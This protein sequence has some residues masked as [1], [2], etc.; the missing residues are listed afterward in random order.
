MIRI[1]AI[2]IAERRSPTRREAAVQEQRAGSETG[3]P[4][5]LPSHSLPTISLPWLRLFSWYSGRYVRRHFHSL[6]VSRAIPFAPPAGVPLVIYSNHASWWDPLV[7][8]LL[9]AEFLPGK[10]VFAPMDAMALKRYGFFKRLGMFGVEQGSRR[11]GVQFLRTARTI[12]QQPN[13]VLWLTPQSRFADARERPV[14]FKPGI[15]H[16]PG[17]TPEIHF[18]PVAI[19][20][21]FWEERLPEVL[22]RFGEPYRATREDVSVKSEWWTEFFADRLR[23]TQGEL[24]KQAQHRDP[25]EFRCLLRGRAGVGGIYDRWRQFKAGWRGKSFQLEHGKL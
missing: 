3:A 22:V 8:L 11:G 12:L 25:T 7:G 9:K 20:Y 4:S 17:M 2:T 23:E 1:E 16:L 19:E 15:G 6:R 21:A 18:V 24:A 5:K 14:R 10:N 13:H